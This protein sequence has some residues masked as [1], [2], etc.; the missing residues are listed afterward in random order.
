M[1]PASLQLVDNYYNNYYNNIIC[2]TDVAAHS[3]L[4]VFRHLI[5]IFRLH[6]LPM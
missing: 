5:Q 1:W 2:L 3:D 6:Y 4:F